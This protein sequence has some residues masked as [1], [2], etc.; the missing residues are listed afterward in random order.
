MES[1]IGHDD[2]LCELR[3]L[4]AS[5]DP[6]HALLFAGPEGTGRAALALEYARL[7]NC[8]ILNGAAAPS[9]SVGLFGDVAVPPAPGPEGR[10]CGI[11][12]ACRLISDGTHPDVI[13][14][15]P[16]DALCRPRASDSGHASH[17]DSRDIRICQVRGLIDLAAKFPYEARTRVIVI[18]PAERMG[19]EAA[20]TLLKTLEEPPGHSVFVLI[21]AAPES[22]L[23]TVVSRCRRM[24]VRTVPRA[25]IEAGLIL[26]GIAPELAARTAR[27]GHGRPGKAI[28]FAKHPDLMDDRAR[29][30]DRC[31]RIAGQ[32]AS[33][34]ITRAVSMHESWRNGQRTVV[35]TELDSW[36]AFWEG[37][38]RVAAETGQHDEARDALRALDAVTL[39]RADLQAN[40]QVRP[41]MELM[42]LSF[43]RV[44]LGAITS[45]E[46]PASHA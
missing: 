21:T 43:P 25:E 13:R 32:R 5:A 11:C 7:L 24:D 4:A 8:E 26:R 23:E 12:R 41:A 29:L 17:R 37:R 2:L 40:V 34:R 28:T 15:G 3:T 38:L 31:G 30:L 27:E 20:N 36:E 42:L 14:L 22:L 44:T 10:P 19:R 1:I 39:G 33:E 35:L 18:D 46:V 9:A 45:E 6:P 16:G